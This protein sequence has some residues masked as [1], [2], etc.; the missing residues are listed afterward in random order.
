MYNYFKITNGRPEKIVKTNS[1]INTVLNPSF[2]A[3]TAEQE[4]FYTENPTATV[5]E[6]WTCHKNVPY[7]PTIEELRANAISMLTSTAEDV[8]NTRVDLNHFCEAVAGTVYSQARGVDSIVDS[9]EILKRA[10][11]YLTIGKLCSDRVA[12]DTILI[13]N[14]STEEAINTITAAAMQYFDTLRTEADNLETH[15]KEKLREIDVYDTSSNVNGF[16]YNGNLLWLDKDTRTGLVN[17]LNSADIVG[18]EHINIWFSGLYITLDTVTA[19][20]MLAALEIYATDCYN[21]TA[22]HKVAVNALNTIEDVDAFDIT[23]D[24]PQRLVFNTEQNMQGVQ[25]VQGEQGVQGIQ[26]VSE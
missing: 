15:K 22:Q 1:Q 23:A 19:R 16:F 8:R 3:F 18:R 9:E 6:V 4:A 26:G 24:Y 20:Q 21:V 12:A 17:T 2:R 25:G 14:A 11:D 13:N 7:V 10:D 5:Y